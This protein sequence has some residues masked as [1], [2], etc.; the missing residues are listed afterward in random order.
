MSRNLLARVIVYRKNW[1][2]KLRFL[3][4][5]FI[6]LCTLFYSGCG[7]LG[8]G[9]TPTST[10]AT[11]IK[12]NHVSLI[13]INGSFAPAIKGKPYSTVL[14]VSGGSAPYTFSLERG[15]LPPGLSLSASTGSVSGVPVQTGN[16]SFAVRAAD[17]L[18]LRFGAKLFNIV[19]EPPAGASPSVIV[20][21]GAG[22]VPSGGKLQFT[23]TVRNISNPTVT[24]SA[25]AG[26]LSTTGLF[27]APS[28]TTMKLVVVTAT[29]RMNPRI[30]GSATISVTPASVLHALVIVN[31]ALIGARTGVPY[32][33]SVMAQG[34]T[35]P[36]TWALSGGLLPRGL[37][38][39]SKTGLISGLALQTGSANF[40]VKVTDAASHAATQPFTI[41]VSTANSGNYDGPAE[42][43]RVYVQSA[44]AN[45]PAPGGVVSVNA[46]GDLQSALNNANC[47]DTIQL[48]A[49]AIFSGQ[50]TFP[51]KSCDDAHWIIVRTS[52]P[53]S[54][55][56]P[57]GTRLTPCFAGISSLPSRPS[58]HCASTI[59][60]MAKIAAASQLVPIVF[61]PGANHYR[62][63]GLEI[64]RPPGGGPVGTLTTVQ[65]GGTVDH[66]VYDRV[67]MHG[68]PQ[69]ETK[70]G[71]YLGG[72]SYVAVV[73]SFF[74][75]FHC[76][77]FT[78][79]CTDAESILGGLGDLPMGP[80]KI[81][82][83]FLEASGEN[84]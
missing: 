2:L 39:N 78:G 29:S 36:Y 6:A 34:G 52:A 75:D 9:F 19:V 72:S 8:Q 50:F 74:T 23:A 40:A 28:V 10:S 80:Y 47:G 49:G 58:F 51:A 55:L 37:S 83:N 3:R 11:N 12:P 53:D 4:I 17:H 44:M 59:N 71:I 48:Q 42:L 82:N 84:I 22:T 14:S 20:T 5:V 79:T 73:D 70:R 81:V 7:N 16:F 68:T 76:T 35:P 60:V 31:S 45:T 13:V 1:P 69:D 56:P 32:S 46:G 21:S 67:W 27:T 26:T 61:A 66:I 54:A 18:H 43:P 15:N 33:A 30:D 41:D 77:A 63:V 65:I 57:E 24:W 64:T 62:L 38:L 25:S